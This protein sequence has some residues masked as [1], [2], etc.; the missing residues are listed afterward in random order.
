[1][2]LLIVYSETKKGEVVSLASLLHEKD[3]R[4]QPMLLPRQWEIQESEELHRYLADTTHWLFLVAPGDLSNPAFLFA[5]GFCV[6]VHERCYLLDVEGALVPGYWKTLFNVSPDFSSL[7]Q[8]LDIERQ[9]WAAHLSRLEAKGKLVERG[10]EVTNS[11]FIEAV[12]KGDHTSCE[13]F[14]QAGFSPDLTDKKGVSILGLAVRSAHLGILRLLLDG[15][16]DVNL[17]SKDRDN[18][19]LMD[20]AAEGLFEIVQE[21]ILRGA[22]LTGL[23]RNGQNALVLAIGKG[24]Q[25]VAGVLLDAGADPFVIDKLGM[26]ACQYAQLLGRAQFLEQVKIKYPGRV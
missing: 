7:V 10:L 24:A 6:A 25:D 18:S 4:F 23:S 2:D 5:S 26:N 15:G 1:L 8:T 22:G 13:L 17:R 19:P 11:A 3:I 20:A 21:L 14:L 16:A 9:R 12:E